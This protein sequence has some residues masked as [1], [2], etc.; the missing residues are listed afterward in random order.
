MKGLTIFFI[1]TFIISFGQRSDF[2]SISFKKADSIANNYK[3]ENLK[4]LPLLTQKLTSSLDTEVEKF[5]AIYTWVCTNIE[6]DYSS[7][8]KTKKNRKKINKDREAF[9]QWN[10]SFT[11]KVFKKL[12]HHKKTACTGYAYLIRELAKLAALECKIINGFGRTANL[13]L[14]KN[15]LPN[16]SWNVVKLNDKWY[17]SDATWSA[18]RVMIEEGEPKFIADY[19]DGYFLG[20]PSLFIKNHYPL[21]LDWTLMTT[22]PSF[23]QFINGPIVYK[24][25]F[26]N[27]IIPVSPEVMHIEIQKNKSVHFELLQTKQFT[28]E[29]IALV[30]VNGSKS[31]TSTPETIKVKNKCTL[32]HTFNKT[33]YYDV[34][35]KVDGLIIATYTVK[36]RK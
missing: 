8:L 9:L 1:F 36:T 4:N 32:K 14:D 5:R 27:G 31:I 17:L 7:Y 16:H 18:G 23:S 35:I 3:G 21:D 24:E 12:L 25:A 26:S 29:E 22:T 11:P 33:G 15:S 30:I 19:F 20:E 2:K 34:H 10:S 28:G 13:K 6:N